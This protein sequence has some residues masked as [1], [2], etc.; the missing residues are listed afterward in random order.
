MSWWRCGIKAG[1]RVA[2]AARS[3]SAARFST[4][5]TTPWHSAVRPGLSNSSRPRSPRELV[6]RCPAFIRPSSAAAAVIGRALDV[7]HEPVE[8]AAATL[9]RGIAPGAGLWRINRGEVGRGRGDQSP[10]SSAMEWWRPISPDAAKPPTTG[11]STLSAATAVGSPPLADQTD[12]SAANRP[13]SSAH[14]CHAA[15]EGRQ[16]VGLADAAALELGRPSQAPGPPGAGIGEHLPHGIPPGCG[17]CRMRAERQR[18]IPTASTT[19]G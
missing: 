4:W 3:R 11:S 18:R 12:G 19:A 6:S 16:G 5:T 8:T 15:D 10:T 2:Q 14:S 9:D 7:T 17:G 13:G 1:R